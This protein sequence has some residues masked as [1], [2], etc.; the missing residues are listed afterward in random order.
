MKNPTLLNPSCRS[1][2]GTAPSCL[3][4]PSK[5]WSTIQF[6]LIIAL[7]GPRARNF[8]ILEIFLGNESL[9][10]AR[11]GFIQLAYAA[12]T[13]VH[14]QTTYQKTSAIYNR[15]TTRTQ[16]L[17]HSIRAPLLCILLASKVFSTNVRCKRSEMQSVEYGARQTL[18]I[19]LQL[20]PTLT[21]RTEPP[22][23]ALSN[24][25]LD[26]QAAPFR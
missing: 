2:R 23:S 12:S 16:G 20:R 6:T 4:P 5:R 3:Q 15:Y 14:Y 19:S 18:I 8:G 26:I 9:Y 25:N 11:I 22:P 10:R 24:S 1:S 7:S 13:R 17:L 21:I